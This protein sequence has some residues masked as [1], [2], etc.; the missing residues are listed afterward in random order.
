MDALLPNKLM[1][2]LLDT[3]RL[4]SLLVVPH[5]LPKAAQLEANLTVGE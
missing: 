2:T 4:A 3:P 5:G 1:N